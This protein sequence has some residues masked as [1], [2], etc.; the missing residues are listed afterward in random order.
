M[1]RQQQL[2]TIPIYFLSNQPAKS[3]IL[4]AVITKKQKASLWDLYANQP[5]YLVA[6]RNV[7]TF[8]RKNRNL[9]TV[10]Q[11]L[12]LIKMDSIYILIS[13]VILFLLLLWSYIRP[14]LAFKNIGVPLTFKEY[15]VPPNQKRHF[16]TQG[17]T[18]AY[19]SNDCS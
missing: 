10:S 15:M 18:T 19:K 14:W 6:K 4:F 13:F 8:I 7:G 2:F 17:H 11:T 5:T 12:Q 1:N 9:D 16:L 3:L